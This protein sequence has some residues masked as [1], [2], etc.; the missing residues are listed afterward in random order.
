MS[1][2]PGLL[3][4]F[5][6]L[7][8]RA[9]AFYYR[10]VRAGGAVPASGPV[11]LVA[12]HP[13][14]LLDPAAVCAVAGR[15][16]RFLAKAPLFRQPVIGRLVRACGAIPVYRRQ[17]DPELM[18][19]NEETFRAAHAALEGGDAVGIFPEGI[20]H[21]EPALAPL[22][23]GA[24]RIA[25]GAANR[26]GASFPVIPVGLVLRRK[27]RFRSEALVVVGEPVAWSELS[28]RRPED[29][30]AVRALTARIEEALRGVTLNLERWEDA[31]AV[32][33]AEAVYAA[34]FGLSGSPEE[35]LRRQAGMA[36]ALSELRRRQPDRVEPLYR[37][38]SRYA[39][40]LRRLELRPDE[41]RDRG[42]PARTVARWVGRQAAFFG[43]AAPVAA[44]GHLAFA[45]PYRLT[46]LL[47][48]RSSVDEDVRSTVKLLGGSV[49]YLVWI[50][51]SA[52]GVA[53]WAGA[54]AGVAAALG[55]VPLGLATLGVR[56]RW[57]EAKADA[58]RYLQLRDRAALRRRLL[59]R[60][61]ELAGRLEDLRRE[62]VAA[63][64]VA[65]TLAAPADGFPR[66]TGN[67]DARSRAA[68]VRDP[69]PPDA[70]EEDE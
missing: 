50:L 29:A 34:E 15:P 28:G 47:A 40:L 51:G 4:W 11:L 39:A 54:W 21:S 9:L 69:D 36:G 65:V 56:E 49:V 43:L 17:D 27:A 16:V 55:L 33:A 44:L 7:S 25:L 68:S 67:T 70:E 1:D 30:D 31:P 19:R 41:L 66:G 35:R 45:V 59:E 6:A 26:I 24:A 57:A 38:V 61:R 60:R 13:N 52:A 48:R 18:E 46:D 32:E 63:E 5:S 22:R 23:T 37:A 64:P 58:R 2:G 20:S 14:S 53:W 12:N 42:P 10:F 62:V 8:R 3:P